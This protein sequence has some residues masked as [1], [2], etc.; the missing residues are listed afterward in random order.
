MTFTLGKL[1]RPNNPPVGNSLKRVVFCQGMPPKIPKAFRFRSYSSL[2]RFTI[3]LNFTSLNAGF[4]NHDLKTV[5]CSITLIHHHTPF[6]CPSTCKISIHTKL[7]ADQIRFLSKNPSN[8]FFQNSFRETELNC[9]VAPK[10]DTG[11][12]TFLVPAYMKSPQ[13]WCTLGEL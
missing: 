5:E 1:K 8:N 10:K 13:E 7:F 4:G 9:F 11:S 3:N 2:P 6:K 12:W